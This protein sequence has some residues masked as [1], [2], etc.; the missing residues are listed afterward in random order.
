MGNRNNTDN[1]SN[2][3]EEDI[4]TEQTNVIFKSEDQLSNFE[5]NVLLNFNTILS[6][7]F[8]NIFTFFCYDYQCFQSVATCDNLFQE[9]FGHKFIE[10]IKFS[11]YFKLQSQ[12]ITNKSVTV[13]LNSAVC[14]NK[15]ISN[16]NNPV[17][18][19]NIDNQKAIIDLNAVSAAANCGYDFD[20]LR[21]FVFLT[22]K[23]TFVNNTGFCYNDRV[24]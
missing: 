15:V 3:K 19:I 12:K 22:T 2:T 21:L 13:E 4:Y 6:E 17:K 1:T 7:K 11:D 24:N 16:I 10:F 14:A 20:K 8:T 9:A 23:E 18:N 5:K